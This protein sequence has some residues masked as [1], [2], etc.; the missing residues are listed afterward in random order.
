VFDPE[1]S[2]RISASTQHMNVDHSCFEGMRAWGLPE[3]VM[4]RGRIIVQD[5][6]FL[7]REGGGHFLPRGA[8]VL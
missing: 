3:L 6:E 1:A 7:G 2:R 4:Q 5:G 8:P